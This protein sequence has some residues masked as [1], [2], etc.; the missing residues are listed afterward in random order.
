MPK[1]LIT[2]IEIPV[3]SHKPMSDIEP[4]CE[5]EEEEED[6]EEEIEEGEEEE[7]ED[8]EEILSSNVR[9]VFSDT[10]PN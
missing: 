10:T 6:T 9:D 4:E 2:G 1:I 7:Y 8:E 5:N 3:R